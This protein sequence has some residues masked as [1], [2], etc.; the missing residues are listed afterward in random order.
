MR[1][2]EETSSPEVPNE[3]P[4]VGGA[5]DSS[6]VPDV[7]GNRKKAS[8]R[9]GE[10]QLCKRGVGAAK[11]VALVAICAA[12]IEVGKLA[13]SFLPN[14]EVVTLLCALFGY[15]F[16]WWGVLSAVVFVFVEIPL[17]GIHTWV[18]SYFLYWPLV[19]LVFLLFR[20]AGIRNRWIFTGAAVLL[21]VWFGVFT[22]LVDV[23]LFT[24]FFD[25]FFYRFGIYYMRGIAFYIVQVVCNLI[26]FPTLFLFLERKI[27]PF[28]KRFLS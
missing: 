17:Y 10:N 14:V 21:T 16:G 1:L 2:R 15:C 11:R 20:K 8:L 24:G 19:S 13:L 7:A 12:T 28:C 26:V 18:I 22:S 4:G 27:S 5:E 3:K 9:A 25:R 6:V 23:G